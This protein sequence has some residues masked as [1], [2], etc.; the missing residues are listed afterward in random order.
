MAR[1]SPLTR[2]AS[3]TPG[4]SAYFSLVTVSN[5]HRRSK[6]EDAASLGQTLVSSRISR[7]NL[8]R[9]QRR[10]GSPDGGAPDGEDDEGTESTDELAAGAGG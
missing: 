10:R 7:S 6:A 3:L 4:V 8:E 5:K 2:E 9:S 1:P